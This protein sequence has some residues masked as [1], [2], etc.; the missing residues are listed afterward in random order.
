[1]I[2]PR[3]EDARR[4]HADEFELLSRFK[5]NAELS[6]KLALAARSIEAVVTGRVKTL[7]SLLKKLIRKPEHTY[8]SLS[9][10]VGLRVISNEAPQAC[11]TI[12]G[13][14]HCV[15]E[16]D[17]SAGLG[18][19]RLGYPGTHLDIELLPDDPEGG[20]FVHMGLRAEIQVRTYAQHAWCD[21]SHRFDYKKDAEDYIPQKLKRRLML[22]VGLLEIADLNLLE[23]SNEIN[24]LPPFQLDKTLNFLEGLYFRLTARSPDR[25]LSRITLAALAS[26]YA[27]GLPEMQARVDRLFEQKKAMLRQ[28][29]ERNERV[30]EARAALFFQP[31]SLVICDL[32][33]DKRD[34]LLEVWAKII[35][36]EEL[37]RLA[38][39]FGYSYGDVE[40]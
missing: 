10:K 13:R 34:A 2:D 16:E 4:K 33:E 35:P 40:S 5:T 24:A 31:E 18:A 38:N 23:V 3:L 32:L 28:V 6:T 8:E 36:E 15:R 20:E 27:G 25:E 39:E 21:V 17:K 14:F 11:E 26:L 9:D 12:R 29:F 7:D 30:P 22:T 1:M 37:Y 19:D